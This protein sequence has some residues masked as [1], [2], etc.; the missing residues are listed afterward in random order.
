[1]EKHWDEKRNSRCKR[2]DA[3]LLKSTKKPAR[4]SGGLKTNED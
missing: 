1:V 2:K 3:R 4:I